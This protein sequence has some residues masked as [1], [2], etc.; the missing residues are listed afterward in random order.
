[1]VQSHLS[2]EPLEEE[3]KSPRFDWEAFYQRMDELC[4]AV[5]ALCGS[6]AA[7]LVMTSTPVE[8]RLSLGLVVAFV[9]IMVAVVCGSIVMAR[10]LEFR[11]KYAK[12]CIILLNEPEEVKKRRETLR[13][14]QDL[15][16]KASEKLAG[17]Q[18]E[19]S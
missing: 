15:A 16:Q 9:L 19:T 6:F 11:Q 3:E 10:Y 4:G 12:L 8:M 5:A 2:Q 18:I 7:V 13:E 14:A 1:M 17:I